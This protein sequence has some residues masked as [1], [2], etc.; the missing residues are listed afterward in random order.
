MPTATSSR[1]RRY[2][3]LVKR[4]M[5]LVGVLLSP[6]YGIISRLNDTLLPSIPIMETLVD[7]GMPLVF[8]DH[9]MAINR[10]VPCV[11]V[12]HE[13][14]ARTAVR[15]LMEQGHHR[16]G[17]RFTAAHSP[18]AIGRHT[19]FRA[20]LDPAGLYC[21]KWVGWGES[22]R[23][24]QPPADRRLFGPRHARLIAR[25]VLGMPGEGPSALVCSSVSLAVEALR[26]AQD[27]GYRVPET[28]SLI[29]LDDAIELEDTTPRIACVQYSL[30][31][32][33]RVT[34]DKLSTL[35]GG[36]ENPTLTEDAKMT[37]MSIVERDSVRPP[38]TTTD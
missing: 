34:M 14:L 37:A 4:T 3:D 26:V 18:A 17:G 23:Q 13:E 31:E 32:V 30:R 19:G 27:S 33:A 12:D 6:A 11:G 9:S 1:G 5:P 35:M 36:E 20:M 2:L 29:C 24:D 38:A 8:L 28:L 25:A 16:I 21:E 7:H 15:F 22:G 10:A